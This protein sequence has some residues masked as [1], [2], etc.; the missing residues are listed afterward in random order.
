M[1]EVQL[2][3]A[4]IKATLE[5]MKR[6]ITRLENAINDA[7]FEGK[8]IEHYANINNYT[9]APSTQACSPEDLLKQLGK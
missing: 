9:H 5:K 2:D 3:I 8:I 7:Y 4:S 1:D 6:D